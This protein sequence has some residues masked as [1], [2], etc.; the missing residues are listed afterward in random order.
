MINNCRINE[1]LYLKIRKLLTID[2][3]SF[4]RTRNCICS[5]FKIKYFCKDAEYAILQRIDKTIDWV[6][7]KWLRRQQ[8]WQWSDKYDKTSFSLCLIQSRGLIVLIAQGKISTHKADVEQDL[9]WV[10]VILK[11]KL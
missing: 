4:S 5:V 3:I 2:T 11:L 9:P 10:Y 6:I 8:L 7:D 1:K